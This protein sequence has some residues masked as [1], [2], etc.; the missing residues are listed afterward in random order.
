MGAVSSVVESWPTFVA[1]IVIPLAV[2]MPAVAE[3]ASIVA[4]DNLSTVKLLA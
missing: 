3:L 1:A 2:A 4:V